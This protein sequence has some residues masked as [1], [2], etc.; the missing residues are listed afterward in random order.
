MIGE[1]PRVTV[2]I[3]AFNSAETFDACLRNVQRQSLA[4]WEC[5]IVDDG[6]TDATRSVAARFAASWFQSC[7]RYPRLWCRSRESNPD[8][9]WLGGF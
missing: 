8:E 6:S 9:R 7:V 1:N 2:R 5:V 3:P 4:D